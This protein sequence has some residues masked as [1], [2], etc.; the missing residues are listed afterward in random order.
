MVCCYECVDMDACEQNTK[1][2]KSELLRT[3]ILQS[4]IVSM[5]FS[6]Y[7]SFGVDPDTCEWSKILNSVRIT[8]AAL[9]FSSDFLYHFP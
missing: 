1:K 8:H 6:D 2:K 9:I 5:V 7:W 4:I 3:L